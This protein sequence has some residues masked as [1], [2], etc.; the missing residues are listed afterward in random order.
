LSSDGH[1][2]RRKITPCSTSL[3]EREKKLCPTLADAPLNT[4]A[5]TSM[6][7]ILARPEE[8][9]PDLG[10]C[11]A[12]QVAGGP[13]PPGFTARRC[14][15]RSERLRPAETRSPAACTVY[16]DGEAV[17]SC[18]TCDTDIEGHEIARVGSPPRR[19]PGP[20]GTAG[21]IFWSTKSLSK[22]GRT[23]FRRVARRTRPGNAQ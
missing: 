7:S 21:D 15:Q 20:D 18:T 10:Q 5:A 19:L 2:P 12:G 22:G 3:T 8:R 4:R 1:A 23:R 14:P 9:A 6:A 17:R 16:Q 13:H 11:D